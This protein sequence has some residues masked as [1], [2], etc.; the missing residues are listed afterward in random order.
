MR[1]QRFS[2]IA[3]VACLFCIGFI[4]AA[5][6]ETEKLT[7]RVMTRNMDAGTDF[8]YVAAVINDPGEFPGAISATVQEVIGSKIPQR[9][10]LLAAE[11]AAAKPDLIAL[12]EVTT[13]EFAPE[14]LG[15]PDPVVLNQLDLL[16]D[17]LQAAGQHYRVAVVQP[18]TTIT[19][20]DEVRP[21][22]VVFID[23]DAILVRTDLPPGH[24]DVLATEA[25]LYDDYMVFPNTPIGD[26]PLLHGWISADIKIRGSRFKFVNTHLESFN[27]ADTFYPQ[28]EQAMQL[29]NDLGTTSLP[30]ILAGDFNS[31]A[32][33]PPHQYPPDAT[34][35]YGYIALRYTDA[36]NALEPM[37]PGYTWPLFGEDQMSG[38][39][40][41]IERID[42]IFSKGPTA[43]S[44]DRTGTEPYEGP[45]PEL[46]GL[47]ASDHTG[48]VATFSLE[49]HRPDKTKK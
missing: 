19:L 15:A 6:A 13:W 49:N 12:Q 8:N 48:V 29:I 4:S 2:R 18:L 26:I 36:W 33:E 45:D 44:I 9:A 5:R 43:I 31:D 25:R 40:V 38:P 30:I 11:I 17:A 10:A 46:L 39:T 16:M 14:V 37:D 1:F 27:V 23:H 24:L 7:A 28:I 41:P 3:L 32:A 47:Y 22:A 42:L 20:P 34:P 35:S 21:D